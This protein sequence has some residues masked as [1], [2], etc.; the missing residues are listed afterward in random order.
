MRS[1]APK[2][3]HASQRRGLGSS[4]GLLVVIFLVLDGVGVDHGRSVGTAASETACPSC[5]RARDHR[6]AVAQTSPIAFVASAAAA[7]SVTTRS[8]TSSGAFFA[9]EIA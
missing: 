1:M 9:A 7:V 6:R 8:S 4:L 2:G 3:R 5:D